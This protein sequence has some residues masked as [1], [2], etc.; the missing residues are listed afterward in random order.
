MKLNNIFIALY[1]HNRVDNNDLPCIPW[2]I[3]VVHV[4]LCC[5]VPWYQSISSTSYQCLS[6]KLWYLQHICVGDT[7]VY[8]WNS[9]IINYPSAC[10]GSIK[11]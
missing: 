4:L 10:E 1:F 5:V 11:I 9:D 7:I 3:H 6:A 8:H 2:I